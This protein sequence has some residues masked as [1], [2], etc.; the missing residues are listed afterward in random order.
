MALMPP[1]GVGEGTAVRT[2]PGHLDLGKTD[3]P[4][5]PCSHLASGP[6]LSPFLTHVGPGLLCP[7]TADPRPSSSSGCGPRKASFLIGVSF[8]GSGLEKSDS[9]VLT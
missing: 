5:C 7:D 3:I 8:K 9:G 1:G 4:V 2:G 6:G